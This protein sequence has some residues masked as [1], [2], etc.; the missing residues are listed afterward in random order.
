MGMGLGKTVSTLTAIRDLMFREFEIDAVLIIAPKRVAS[1][2]WTDEIQKWEHLNHMTVSRIQGTAKQREKALMTKADIYTLGRD[3]V[4]WYFDQRFRPKI[5]ML[6]VDEST[7]FKNHGSKR[8][9]ALKKYLL[10]F[11]RRIILTGTPAPNGYQNLWAQ[12]FIL[13]IGERLE[14][15]ITMFRDKFLRIVH[16]YSKHSHKYELQSGAKESIDHAI[17]DITITMMPE[18]YLDM[19]EKIDNVIYLD[20][21]D[22]LRE[23]YNE[24]VREKVLELEMAD[25]TALNAAALM[26]KLMQF[27]N[28]ATY[29]EDHVAHE[30]HT[31]K[32]D[33]LEELLETD[34]NILLGWSFQH[35][36][37]RIIERFKSINPRILKTDQD[38][39][40][41]NAG[42]IK[43]MLMHPA[44]GGHG[45]NLQEGGNEIVWFGP[46]WDLELKQQFE[47]RIYR[48]GQKKK[49]VVLST[50]V[51]RGTVE[52][53]ALASINSKASVQQNM[54][55][56]VEAIASALPS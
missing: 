49:T 33:L 14:R 12:Y 32:L 20:M 35:D 3:N 41:W 36:R 28:G 46:T 4:M 48:Q 34:S 1:K 24:F 43:M 53:K 30:V 17:A 29:D 22:E 25:I 27:C 56:A 13:D 31:L 52:E 47:A 7:S 40:D 38:I 18:D 21:P 11:D 50:I 8:F 51:L 16:S 37:D 42:K 9:K 2:V 6:V 10:E 44:S 55:D 39:D 23:Q 54:I 26:N 5:N 15:T 19:P 45:L